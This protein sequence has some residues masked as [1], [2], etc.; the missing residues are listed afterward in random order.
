MRPFWHITLTTY[1][2]MLQSVFA[3]YWTRIGILHHKR[4][5]S[6]FPSTASSHQLYRE[7]HWGSRDIGLSTFPGTW[8]EVYCIVV[9]SIVRLHTKNEQLASI[10]A[11]E[12]NLIKTHWNHFFGSQSAT[13][14]QVSMFVCKFKNGVSVWP[15]CV[16]RMKKILH[17]TSAVCGFTVVQHNWRLSDINAN[18][19]PKT[20][21]A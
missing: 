11:S 15:C 13:V 6:M 8:T 21:A 20:F 17:I 4:C 3:N 9:W 2:L 18:W 10:A 19:T 5:T 12:V 14:F 7:R 1:K 16:H